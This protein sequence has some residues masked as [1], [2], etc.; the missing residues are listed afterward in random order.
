MCV[1]VICAKER[2]ERDDIK[3]D[4][5]SVATRYL[6]HF[7]YFPF[8]LNNSSGSYFPFSYYATATTSIQNTTQRVYIICRICNS[9]IPMWFTLSLTPTP[10]SLANTSTIIH[11][12]GFQ[13]IRSHTFHCY[14]AFFA[15][16]LACSHVCILFMASFGCQRIILIHAHNFN[17]IDDAIAENV[18]VRV[19]VMYFIIR[20]RRLLPRWKNLIVKDKDKGNVHGTYTTNMLATHTSTAYMVVSFSQ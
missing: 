8:C 17:Y 16:W 3:K 6:F 11:I 4:E 15:Y 10:L 19:C 7:C 12:S 2:G 20:R 5:R 18:C 9:F 1:C 13:F 14:H